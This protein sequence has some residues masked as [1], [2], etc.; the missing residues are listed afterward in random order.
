MALAGTVITKFRSR[1]QT[2]NSPG[3]GK[4]TYVFG[5]IWVTS[6]T[7]ILTME[8]L[9][10]T[11]V[12]EN[13]LA[14]PP[15][16]TMQCQNTIRHDF[17]HHLACR[18]SKVGRYMYTCRLNASLNTRTKLLA[19]RA[20]EASFSWNKSYVLPYINAISPSKYART[21]NVRNGA[22]RGES[23]SHQPKVSASWYQH[24][25]FSMVWFRTFILIL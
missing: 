4:M 22:S 1:L 25:V 19:L 8:N 13:S 17:T 3:I 21:G 24:T 7:Q 6:S 18:V 15:L 2:F 14:I 5:T 20:R 11:E 23:L 10:D 12:L 9:T 16:L